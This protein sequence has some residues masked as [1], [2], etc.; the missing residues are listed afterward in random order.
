MAVELILPRLEYEPSYGEYIRE[1]G[2]EE[3]HPF[4]LDFEYKDFPALL[5]R[6]SE[7]ASGI[8]LPADFVP[9]STYWLV[10][11]NELVGVSN[12]RHYLNDRIRH[13]GGHIGLGIRPSYRGRGLGNT[14][15]TRTIQEARKKG[16]TEIHIHCHKSNI[17]S[18]R[19]IARNGGVLESEVQDDRSH[20]IIQRYCVGAA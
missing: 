17:P 12:L 10:E 20:E 19:M 18:A 2:T 15:L 3:R 6:L 5:S 4:P 13:H 7:F 11:G 8:N 14:L 16:I 9:S 1:L